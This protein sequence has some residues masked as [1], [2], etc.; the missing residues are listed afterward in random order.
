MKKINGKTVV[1]QAKRAIK[2]RKKRQKEQ[3][4]IRY[5]RVKQWQPKPANQINMNKIRYLPKE[6][7]NAGLS[8]QAMAV[9]PVLC[10]EADFEEDKEFQISRENLSRKSGLHFNG[11]KSGIDE[12]EQS[13]LCSQRLHTEGKRHFYLYTVYFVRK[14]MMK[15]E[16]YFSFH[17]A[18]I[19]SGIWNELMPRAKVL[20][21]AMRIYA[22]FDVQ[23]YAEIEYECESNELS[24]FMDIKSNDFVNR[25]WDVLIN[26]SL[27]KIC[28]K[29]GVERSN[30]KRILRQL[31]HFG[32]IETIDNQLSWYKVY[33]KPKVLATEKE[34]Y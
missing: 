15:E 6:I 31:E 10:C 22:K 33:L 9:Y 3:F 8:K 18:I 32:L 17:N 1:K 21:L 30:R 34:P 4:S 13:E 2:E 20:Y 24:E 23:L 12:L 14:H 29:V 27:N 28:E 11:V 19:E 16:N 7:I 25:K 26:I 5:D